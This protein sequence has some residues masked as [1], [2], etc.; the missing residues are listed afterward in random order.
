ME[1]LVNVTFGFDCSLLFL[2]KI[3]A[4]L[5]ASLLFSEKLVC[6]GGS[7]GWQNLRFSRVLAETL[8]NFQKRFGT[9]S[10][11]RTLSA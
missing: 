2:A 1:A 6:P 3:V 4:V 7:P 5:V 9:F 10:P 8:S 11:A